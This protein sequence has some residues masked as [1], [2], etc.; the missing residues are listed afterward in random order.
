MI[1]IEWTSFYMILTSVRKHG[2][3]NKY[4]LGMEQQRITW[5]QWNNG[6]YEYQTY[7]FNNIINNGY[8]LEHKIMNGDIL[9]KYNK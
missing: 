4:A 2:N 1:N 9:E 6:T 5:N 3:A 7:R 8:R